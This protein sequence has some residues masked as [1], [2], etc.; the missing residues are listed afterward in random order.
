MLERRTDTTISR[1]HV[2][3]LVGAIGG[4]VLVALPYFEVYLPAELYGLLMVIASGVNEY[5]RRTQTRL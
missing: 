5:I 4:S 2:F 3:N 1:T